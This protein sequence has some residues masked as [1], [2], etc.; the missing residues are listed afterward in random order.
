MFLKDVNKQ[1][2][3]YVKNVGPRRAKL[4]ANL[5]IYTIGDLLYHF[6]R[7]YEDRSIIRPVYFFNHGDT[8]TV[9]GRV[10]GGQDLKPRKGLTI[11]KLAV[12]DGSGVFYA[13]WFNQP[14]VK[15]Q[16]KTGTR[17]LVTGKVQ[18]NFGAVQ[19]QVKDFEVL[20]E[21]EDT[22][23]IGRI[24][25][26][27]PATGNLSQRVL[28][29][30]MKEAVEVWA[31][32]LEEFLP[33]SLL[34]KYKLP[35]IRKAMQQIHF[36][37]SAAALRE[38][39]RRF[40]YEELF[41]FQLMVAVRRQKVTREK[42]SFHYQK[43]DL[44]ARTFLER[45]PFKLTGAQEAAWSEISKDM[46][47]LY[48]MNRLLQGDVG[49]GKTVVSTL[50]LLKAVESGFQAAMMAPTEILAEQH[51][52]G[53]KRD[54]E[55]LGVQVALLAGG[56]SKVGRDK[57]IKNVKNGKVQVLVGTHALIQEGVEFKNLALAVIDEQHRFGVRQRAILRQK[58]RQP[59]VLVMTATPIPRTLALTLYGD[60]DVSVI[61]ELP[62]GRQP[63]KTFHVNT[64]E[65]KRVYDLVEKELQKG[66]QAYFVCPLVEESEE[67]EDIRAATELF[68][69]LKVVF[70]S[71][72]VD[73]LH[74]K[75]RS[76]EKEAVMQSFSSGDTA[77]LVSTTVIEVGVDVPNAT[78]MVV[79]DADRFGLAQLH[80]LRG[81]VGRGC[82]QSYCIL[83]ADPHTEEARLRLRAMTSTTDG[84]KLAE[85][86]LR[87]RGPGEFCGTRQSGLPDFKIADIIRDYKIMETARRDARNLISKDP[88]LAKPENKLLLKKIKSK[89]G[90]NNFSDIS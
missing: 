54:L 13:V 42:K 62:P 52:L 41:L 22:L 28:R 9:Q 80:Q 81:R 23:N 69:E 59:D 74:G 36:P 27:Y 31:E 33:S 14:Y 67:L 57:I 73:L 18:K 56:Q 63:V 34:V 47:S 72:K 21:R 19:V 24:V 66:N 20:G 8:A 4:L 70:G 71:F 49:S 64:R 7:R 45:L 55:P 25:P 61:S 50:A 39:R 65:V 84:F 12:D 90:K 85:E 2:V 43:N 89:Y 83:V 88:A 76:G 87:L 5:G 75:M 15:K 77:V 30:I 35:G 78:V 37:D 6:P 26:F 68:K 44:L 1:Q 58:G 3:Q 79:M 16:L 38:A 40:I 10:L 17:I 11:T 29:V 48:P 32:V 86:D 82:A 46:Q 53:L 51:Y 60:L